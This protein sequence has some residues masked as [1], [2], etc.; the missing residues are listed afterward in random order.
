M[1]F[2]DNIMQGS[3]KADEIK[4]ASWIKSK[5]DEVRSGAVR[6]AHESIWMQN[7]AAVLGFSGL[8]YNATTKTF[9]PINRAGAALRK[10]R[11]NVNKLLP[12]LQTRL[13]KLTKSPPK[14]DVRPN[15]MTQE[16]RDNARFKL[17]ILNAKWDDLELNQK[18]YELLMYVEQCG[19]A[20]LGLYWDDSLGNLIADPMTGEERFEG[21]MRVDVISPFEVFP[22]PLAKSFDEA[23]YWIRCKIRPIDYFVDQYGEKGAE[24]KEEEVWL[25]SSQFQTR[26]NSMNTKGTTSG[27]EG[28]ATKHCAIEMTYIERPSKKY[29]KGRM[30][31]SANGVILKQAEL[32][33]GKIN[34]VKFDCAVIGGKYYSE[35]FVTHAR[36][37]Q[38]QFN[39][40][41]RRRTDWTNKLLNGKLI[42][43]KGA[44]IIREGATDESGEMIQYTPVPNAPNGGEPHSMDMPNIPSYAYEEEARLDAQMNEI[45]GLGDMDK[46]ILPAAGIPAI[47]MQLLLEGSEQR[48]SPEI[49]QHEMS[50]AKFGTLVLDYVQKLYKTPRKIKFLGKSSY[51]VK[52]VEG[53]SLEGCNDVTVIRGSSVP[54]SKALRR[55]ELLNAYDRGLLGDPADM[56]VR[57]NVLKLLEYGDIGEIYIDE[58]LSQ[59]RADKIAKMVR[60]NQMPDIAECDPHFQILKELRRIRISDE[61]DTF[62]QDRKDLWGAVFEECLRL[63]GEQ[64]GATPPK[65]SPEEEQMAMG[66]AEAEFQRDAPPPP[67]D[68]G[69]EAPAGAQLDEQ[70]AAREGNLI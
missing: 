23:K 8:M 40:V 59:A 70:I 51:I 35:S 20:Y 60:Q 46:G 63:S 41:I 22:D 53:G 49:E 36:P 18:R 11:I 34:I 43:A 2:F 5:V 64:T 4:L 3:D 44:E 13:A 12:A 47:G 30:I 26:I 52:E 33:C 68:I 9:Q 27:S 69:L 56:N 1:S 55:Q 50:F 66:E 57:A 14:Y 45:M 58:A 7:I 65:L 61:Y 42:Y 62:D 32:P 29:P 17:D 19:H 31:V 24:V 28:G 10:N 37:I 48:I 21:D 38:D 25:L 15:D 54:S 39:N 6:T 16:S 67:P